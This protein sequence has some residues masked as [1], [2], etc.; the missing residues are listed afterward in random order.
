VYPVTKKPDGE[1][2][3]NLDLTLERCWGLNSMYCLGQRGFKFVVPLNVFT[4]VQCTEVSIE[5]LK[6]HLQDNS[7]FS[8][9]ENNGGY[10][11]N[12]E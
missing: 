3:K 1:D 2:R 11:T 7:V 6:G 8:K 5:R 10:C 9:R 4:T 12:S